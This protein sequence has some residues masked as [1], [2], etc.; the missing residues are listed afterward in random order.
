M[1]CDDCRKSG[2][3]PPGPASGNVEQQPQAQDVRAA[4]VRLPSQL[5]KMGQGT[6]ALGDSS[7]TQAAR[8]QVPELPGSARAL[9][10]GA[11]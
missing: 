11:R 9:P 4:A 6:D 10:F 3:D 5:S 2:S 1:G 8:H 7:P